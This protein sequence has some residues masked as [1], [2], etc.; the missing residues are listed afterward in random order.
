MGT[1]SMEGERVSSKEN[2]LVQQ[3]RKN[4]AT[5]VEK[6]QGVQQLGSAGELQKSMN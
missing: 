3:V 2:I 5:T 4:K 1:N 6:I